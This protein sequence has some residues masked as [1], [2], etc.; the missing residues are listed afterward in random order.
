[1]INIEMIATI[2]ATGKTIDTVKT[3]KLKEIH[4]KTI[5]EVII[6]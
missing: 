3:I 1:M 4:K 6:F 5:S 2:E